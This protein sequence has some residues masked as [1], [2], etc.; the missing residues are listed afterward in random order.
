M[1]RASRGDRSRRGTRR[2][3]PGEARVD[4]A[5]ERG[6]VDRVELR[7]RQRQ[8]GP[9]DSALD[10][11]DKGDG[12]L[13]AVVQ[14]RRPDSLDQI[15]RREVRRVH[16]DRAA[17]VD[18]RGR[19]REPLAV[20]GDAL[21]AGEPELLDEDP[22][23]LCRHQRVDTRPGRPILEPEGE[24]RTGYGDQPGSQAGLLEVGVEAAQGFGGA[25]IL[26]F[27]LADLLPQPEDLRLERVPLRLQ[28][29]RG[30]DQRGAL[31]ARVPD[32]RALGGD[33]GGDEEAEDEQR[34]RE[35]DLDAWQRAQPRD[36]DAHCGRSSS[37][38]AAAASRSAS[39]SSTAVGTVGTAGAS[40][41][42]PWL[43][44][45]ATTSNPTARSTASKAS[46]AM[47]TGPEPSPAPGVVARNVGAGSPEAPGFAVCAGAAAQSGG[48]GPGGAGRGPNGTGS[49]IPR[50]ASQPASNPAT[51]TPS[52]ALN[53]ASSLTPPA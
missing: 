38:P 34:H 46:T 29:Q 31:L 53:A 25:G 23:V 14:V 17:D 30:V 44:R 5:R 36:E 47:V 26:R 33:L 8:A 20:D 24:A 19:G 43:S 51:S 4:G 18:D 37:P 40:S 48:S 49:E 22:D 45:R 39:S 15:R 9:L 50:S 13:Q 10:E 7:D 52:A 28:R 21:G 32:A 16:Q 27:E 3:G 1:L 12:A 2:L 35:G 41:G 11:L 6:Q 42:S